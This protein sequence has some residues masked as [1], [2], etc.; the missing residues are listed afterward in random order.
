MVS[1][2]KGDS[3]QLDLLKSKSTQNSNEKIIL[4]NS[5]QKNKEAKK[6]ESLLILDTETSGLDEKE[7]ELIE[8][9][10]ILFHVSSR[11]I[12][13]QLSFLLPVSINQAEDINGIAAEI[14]HYRQPWKDGINFFL[15]LVETSDLIVAHNVEFDK[16]WFGIGKL[17]VLN[18]KWICSLEDI[19][20][21]FVKGL[22]ARPSV[23]D[24]ALAFKIPVWNLH[25]ALSDCYYISE[26][27]KRC[28]NLEELLLKASEPRFLFK[29]IVSYEQRE[30]AKQAGFRWNQP[31][32]GAWTKKMSKDEAS[33]LD[34]KVLLLD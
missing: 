1:T 17:P 5:Y 20:W 9:G 34:F 13:S 29:A 27:F 10:C 8:I 7:N 31:V 30:L 12:L 18:K 19:N 11:T 22:R 25:R 3:N 15:K 6:I 4:N 2:N 14:T 21:S 16:K 28:E 26:V 24:L 33:T 32:Q 23:T